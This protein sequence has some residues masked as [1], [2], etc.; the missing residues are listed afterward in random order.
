MIDTGLPEAAVKK[1]C[2][3]LR[4]YP[5]ISRVVLYGSRAMG[6]YRHGSDIDLCLDAERLG[7]TELLAIEN[8]I[9]DLLLPWKVDLSLMHALDNPALLEHIRRVGVD[10]C[11][12]KGKSEDHG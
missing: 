5:R 11:R 3:I 1:I 2:G 9:D 7:L 6:T 12:L 4:D 8:R 10:F